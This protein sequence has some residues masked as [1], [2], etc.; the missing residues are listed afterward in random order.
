MR[1]SIVS[2][3]M[4]GLP[5]YF[6]TF[7][8]VRTDV[9]TFGSSLMCAATSELLIKPSK[10]RP[11]HILESHYDTAYDEILIYKVRGQSHI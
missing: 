1:I 9:L 6:L 11:N 5:I 7:Q 2:V 4:C 10:P 8:V 3:C